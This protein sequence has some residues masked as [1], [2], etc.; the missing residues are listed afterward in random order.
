MTHLVFFYNP[1]SR[2]RIVHWMLEEVGVP[3][4]T[5]LVRFDRNEHK[6]PEFLAINPMGKLPTI[7]HG[8]TVVTEAGAIC[9]YLADAFPAAQL[10]PPT[11]SPERGTYYRW[12]FFGAGCFEPAVIDHLFKRVP[13][14]RPSSIGYGTYED[15]LNTLEKA[16]ARGPFLLGERFS[17]ADVYVGSQIR[18]ALM[19]KGIESRPVFEQYIARCDARPASQR[20]NA[21]SEKYMQELMP[22]A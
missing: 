9:A 20:S 6:S 11:S 18:W 15:T 19:T 4:E 2:A 5:R 1:M 16:L 22:K 3:Y 7:K 13:V 21:Q 10:A 8:D 17:A 14:E 12:M